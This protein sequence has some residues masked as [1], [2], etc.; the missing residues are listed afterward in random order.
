MLNETNKK[1]KKQMKMLVGTRC[2]VLRKGTRLV[3]DLIR[4]KILP[5]N[6]ILDICGFITII[7]YLSQL[8]LI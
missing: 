6:I 2:S 1:K 4:L 5:N 7:F 8:A 3:K